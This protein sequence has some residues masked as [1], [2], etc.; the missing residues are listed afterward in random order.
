MASVAFC[1]VAFASS[2]SAQQASTEV[3]E[4][5][6]TGSRIQRPNLEAS[7]PLLGTS[8]IRAVLCLEAH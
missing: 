5:V 4:L 3:G 7:Q 8:A 6:V 1:G 2:A